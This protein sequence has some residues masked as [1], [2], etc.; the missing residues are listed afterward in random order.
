A[1][2]A[3]AP[4][5]GTPGT[6][7]IV[8]DG[9]NPGAIDISF[10]PSNPAAQSYTIQRAVVTNGVPGAFTNVA[11]LVTTNNPTVYV[12]S[13]VAAGSI[14]VYRIVANGNGTA[15]SGNSNQLSTPLVGAEAHYYNMAYWEGP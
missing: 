15:T 1:S 14:Y 7:T 9:A 13:S 3:I 4:P 12:D 5:V 10:A 11:G 2:T 6:P 8:Q